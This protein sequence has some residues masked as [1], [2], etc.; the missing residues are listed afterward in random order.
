[1]V[2]LPMIAK[3]VN[4][5][6]IAAGGIID[7]CSMAASFALGAQGIQMGTRMV[8]SAE[9][10]VH[11]NWKDAIVKASDQDTMILNQFSSPALRVLRTNRTNALEREASIDYRAEFANVQ[12]LYFG[13][14]MEAS[15][16]LTGQV[17]GRIESVKPVE[18]I[19]E[20][21][22]TEFYDTIHS[23]GANL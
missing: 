5:P 6:V 17:A 2:L 11:Q 23:L 9:S 14:D 4:V 20:E 3:K 8:S 7:G 19:I 16:A 1:M 21:T 13:G 22:M 10:P 18:Q 12:D 15:A